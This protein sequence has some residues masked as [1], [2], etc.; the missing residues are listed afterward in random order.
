M[1]I[2]YDQFKYELYKCLECE[3][4]ILQSENKLEIFKKM[5]RNYAKM[6]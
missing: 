2:R 6:K 4:C 1:A 3:K 5:V